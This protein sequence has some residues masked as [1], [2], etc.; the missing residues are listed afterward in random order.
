ML[1]MKVLVR[2]PS[3]DVYFIRSG[4]IKTY[5]SSEDENTLSKFNIVDISNV[6]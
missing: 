3:V 6:I 1:F 5:L 4:H 2:V